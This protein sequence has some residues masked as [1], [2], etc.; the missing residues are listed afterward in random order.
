MIH[1]SPTSSVFSIGNSGKVNNGTDDYIA[2]C[3]AEKKGYSKF[4]STQ[5]MEMLM[6]HL[7]TQDLNLLLL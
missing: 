2:Y 4:G 5:V 1:K 6:D 3:F 7:F